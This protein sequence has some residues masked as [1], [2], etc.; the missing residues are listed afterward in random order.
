RHLVDHGDLG[1]LQGAAAGVG[2]TPEVDDGSD[3]RAAEGDV[4]EAAAPG[5]AEGV[6]YDDGHPPTGTGLDGIPDVAGR[7][8]GVDGQQGGHSLVDVRDVDAGVGADEAVRGLGD[9]QLVAAAQDAHR[10]P[11]DEPEA[12]VVVDDLFQTTLC[13]RDDLLGDHDHVAVLHL[14]AL[15]DEIGDLVAGAH[16][17]QPHD[18]EDADHPS[19][20]TRASAAASRTPCIT[21]GVTTHLIP[22]ASTSAAKSASASSTTSVPANGEYS[23]AT[24]TT[25]GSTPSSA[26]IRSAGPLRAAPATMGE[27]ATTSCRRPV[28]AFCTPGTARMGAIERMGLDGQMTTRCASV[29]ASSTFGAGD[30]FSAPAYST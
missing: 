13:L 9:Q 16:L 30:A 3:A 20:T 22:S 8:V 15:E 21:V 19:R 29:M 18:G 1:G 6:G 4:D 17:R 12:I 11:L 2:R 26:I 27:T 23:R 5:A 10:L 7:P 14:R 25:D 28:I 24:P